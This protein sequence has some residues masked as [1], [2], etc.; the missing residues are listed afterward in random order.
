MHALIWV[1]GR[2]TTLLFKLENVAILATTLVD[3]QV[4]CMLQNISIWYVN[5][6]LEYTQCY[7][8]GGDGLDSRR[9]FTASLANLYGKM[10][11]II[12]TNIVQHTVLLVYTC[13]FHIS[14]QNIYASTLHYNM[15]TQIV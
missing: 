13:T 8:Y 1:K 10:V 11:K 12:F 4:N 3:S 7:Y 15:D 2:L 6:L 9:M 14:V 5:G